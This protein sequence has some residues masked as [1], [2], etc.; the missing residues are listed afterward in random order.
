M[1]C[2]DER[3]SPS[4]YTREGTTKDI[5]TNKDDWIMQE[6]WLRQV[7]ESCRRGN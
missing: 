6:E 3:R 2:F 5:C 4:G 1:E 7:L